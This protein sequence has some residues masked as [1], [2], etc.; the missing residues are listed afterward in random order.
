MNTVPNAF[1]PRTANAFPG[2][3][4]PTS[5]P[6][7]G[8]VPPLAAS[9]LTGS[10]MGTP[11]SPQAAPAHG[12]PMAPVPGS[13]VSPIAQLVAMGHFPATNQCEII[14]QVF[15]SKTMPHGFRWVPGQPGR[16]GKLEVNVKL[17]EAW[18]G[19]NPGV[20]Q[21][22]IKMVAFGD[23]GEQVAGPPAI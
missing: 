12:A 21:S 7:A 19:S 17:R 8:Y 20:R 3:P 11:H 16:D 13:T 2:W 15:P 4:G 18:G 22:K 23:L 10:P 5:G 9:P 6:W 1:T 14:G